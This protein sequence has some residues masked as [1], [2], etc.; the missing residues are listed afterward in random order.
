[1]AE[2]QQQPTMSDSLMSLLE[3]NSRDFRKVRT[4]RRPIGA[5]VSGVYAGADCVYVTNNNMAEEPKNGKQT[6]VSCCAC[7]CLLKE[8][9]CIAIIL[10]MSNKAT[11]E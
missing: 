11:Y 1:M 9:G 8:L 4:V 5:F 2:I 7:A 3:L 10:C 6:F